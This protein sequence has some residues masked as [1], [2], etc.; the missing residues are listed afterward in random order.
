VARGAGAFSLDHLLR[1][2]AQPLNERR[3]TR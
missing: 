1:P 2:V 3:G